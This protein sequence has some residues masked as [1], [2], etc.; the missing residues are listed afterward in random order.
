REHQLIYL[1]EKARGKGQPSRVDDLRLA[2]VRSSHDDLLE[3]S[4]LVTGRSEAAIGLLSQKPVSKSLPVRILRSRMVNLVN[5][6]RQ[7]VGFWV[8]LTDR[9]MAFEVGSRLRMFIPRVEVAEVGPGG[10]WARYMK[11]IQPVRLRPG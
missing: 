4:R 3:A 11:S 7:P 8:H 6:I 9:Q 10:Q 2:A 1:W 5:R